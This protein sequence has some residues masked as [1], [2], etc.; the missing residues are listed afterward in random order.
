M[1][2]ITHWAFPISA[3]TVPSYTRGTC[4]GSRSPNTKIHSCTLMCCPR[5]HHT[6][7]FF[8]E[9]HEKTTGK[10]KKQMR[11]DFSTWLTINA[12]SLIKMTKTERFKQFGLYFLL[13]RLPSPFHHISQKIVSQWNY[14]FRIGFSLVCLNQLISWLCIIY[15]GSIS[16][17]FM[18]PFLFCFSFLFGGG[19]SALV[20]TVLILVTVQGLI[21]DTVWAELYH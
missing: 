21:R 3:P 4:S 6:T 14:K 19:L 17:L 5:N 9:N 7:I 13:W 11:Y 18:F 15:T 1:C 12:F 10:W 2:D 8:K 20:F 16:F